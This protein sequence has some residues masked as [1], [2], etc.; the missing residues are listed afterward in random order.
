MFHL[1]PNPPKNATIHHL[2]PSPSHPL[3]S[4]K[5]LH[6]KLQLLCLENELALDV[7]STATSQALEVAIP[8]HMAPLCPQ[9]RGI[10]R[11]YK[12]WVEGCSEGPSTSHAA[13]CVH[14]HR[15]HLGVR[16]VCPSHTKTFL[17][18]DTLMCHR[19]IHNN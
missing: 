8:A 11:V 17:N 13:I 9:L 7:P 5:K 16:L 4:L 2:P 10:K 18:S 3:R 14:V 15:D 1:S 6:L 12:C 19:K